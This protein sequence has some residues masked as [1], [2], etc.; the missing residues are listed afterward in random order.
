MIYMGHWQQFKAICHHLKPLLVL[1]GLFQFVFG[2]EIARKLPETRAFPSVFSFAPRRVKIYIILMQSRWPE[3]ED[4][5]GKALSQ[6]AK[7]QRTGQ[8]TLEYGYHFLWNILKN[9]G[10]QHPIL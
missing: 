2:L 4:L 5:G 1:E 8:Q 10:T 7:R 3:L 6:T 9:Q